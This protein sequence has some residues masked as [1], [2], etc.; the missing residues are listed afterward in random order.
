MRVTYNRTMLH[1]NLEN[2]TVEIHLR[3]TEQIIK[4]HG[5]KQWSIISGKEKEITEIEMS[6]LVDKYH[7]YLILELT[8][9]SKATF[10]NNNVDMFIV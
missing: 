4:Y 3:D 9:G 2:V 8:D 1:S 10:R 7:E 5:L 6:G